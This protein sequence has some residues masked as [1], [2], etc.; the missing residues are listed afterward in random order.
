MSLRN[1]VGLAP[2]GNGSLPDGTYYVRVTAL[3]AAGSAAS[4]ERQIIVTGSR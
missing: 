2:S 4:I 3:N 1:N